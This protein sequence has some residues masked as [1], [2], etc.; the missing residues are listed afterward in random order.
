MDCREY[1]GLRDEIFVDV[2]PETGIL[3]G[4]RWREALK[5]A[6]NR[7]E[8][9]ICLL[10]KNWESSTECRT[11]FRTA[12]NLNKLISAPVWNQRRRRPTGEWQYFDLFGG[13]VI[14]VDTGTEA[15]SF[16][17]DGLPVIARNQAGRNRRDIV[18]WPPPGQPDRA[19]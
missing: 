12:E 10:S 9:V 2:D 13:N 8:A 18:P 4:V 3:P 1:P 15:V 6:N 17:A 11:E 14:Q 19:P 7:C 16:N 5:R